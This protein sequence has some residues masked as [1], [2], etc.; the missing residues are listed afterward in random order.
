MIGRI[1]K[2]KDISFEGNLFPILDSE[3]E[4]LFTKG[5]LAFIDA[6]SI[7]SANN[8]G[9]VF[10]ENLVYSN[11]KEISELSN[12]TSTSLG[13]TITGDPGG[14]ITT[15]FSA[16]GGLHGITKE[17]P[18]VG[19]RKLTPNTDLIN[20]IN[21]NYTHKFFIGLSHRVTS[22]VGSGTGKISYSGAFQTDSRSLWAFDSRIDYLPPN[23]SP[24]FDNQ[25]KLGSN[26]LMYQSISVKNGVYSTFGEFTPPFDDICFWKV[27]S[28]SN[29]D[30]ASSGKRP[31]DIFYTFYME[32]LTVS[33]RT[34][35]EVNNIFKARHIQNHS[36]GGKY[37]GDTW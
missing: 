20:Y 12:G 6:K 3:P 32:D 14:E 19:W 29:F 5:S 18:S 28:N 1:I 2:N 10:V 23:N 30:V 13:A 22:P 37:Y 36:V 8:N 4:T 16:K 15:S 33:G 27:G 21:N 31:S 26:E 17:S 25:D 9:D 24:Y 34:F 7:T 35:D 11:A